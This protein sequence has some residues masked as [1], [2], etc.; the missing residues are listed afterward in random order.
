[1]IELGGYIKLINFDDTQ[2]ALLIV[3]KKVVG[4]YTKKISEKF[5]DFK[6]IEITLEDK[7][8]NEIRVKVTADKVHET[9]AK[10][11]N[12]FFSLDRA[13]GGILKG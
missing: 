10:D 13:L 5:P 9:Q 4:N 8:A 6:N 2:P 7:E 11:K 3:I 12:L 1:M